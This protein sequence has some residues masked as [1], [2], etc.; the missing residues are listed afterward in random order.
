MEKFDVKAS[1]PQLYA[2]GR[3][4]FSLVF[5]PPW[6]TAESLARAAAAAVA[7]KGIPGVEKLHLMTLEEGLCA[8]ILHIGPYDDEA[9]LLARLH[10]DWM[11]SHGLAFNGDHHEVYLS[12]PRR[13]APERL[14]T[15]LRQPV[16]QVRAEGG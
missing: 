10:H 11:P 6:I 4:E 8:Q 1:Y 14:R 5:Q 16:R 9:P 15:V 3:R 12:D 13:T 7:K 2:P